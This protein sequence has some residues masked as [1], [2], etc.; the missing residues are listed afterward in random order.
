[1]VCDTESK[2]SIIH[3]VADRV[4]IRVYDMI[5]DEK[6]ALK[7]LE[8][9]FSFNRPWIFSSSLRTVLRTVY[10]SFFFFRHLGRLGR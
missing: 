9:H 8:P 1:M 7:F 2:M 4:S 10:F 6:S 5:A 3:E